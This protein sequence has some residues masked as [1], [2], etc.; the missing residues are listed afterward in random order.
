MYTDLLRSQVIFMCIYGTYMLL[1]LI[2]LFITRCFHYFF[3][4]HL[5][6]FKLNF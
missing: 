3:F 5:L 2:N 4:I 1:L 6:F